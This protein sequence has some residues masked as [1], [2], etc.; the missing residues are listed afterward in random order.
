[1]HRLV[2]PT[3]FATL[4]TATA[5]VTIAVN[6]AADASEH[7]IDWAAVATL[8]AVHVLTT[9]EDGDERSTKIW[10]L[11]Q[12]GKGYIRTS[13]STTWGDNAE[14]STILE[15]LDFISV[16]PG[17]CRN[18]TNISDEIG[19]LYVAIQAPEG[20]EFDK[21]AFAPSLGEEIAE[22]FGADTVARMND[23]GVK[24]DAGIDN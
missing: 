10:L 22:K 17:V 15:P 6:S 19:Y 8:K 9:D 13:Q 24:F 11:V 3:R 18:F 21:V 5:A 20:D 1:M 23:I 12:G 4:I 16:P 7:E 14:H 2:R